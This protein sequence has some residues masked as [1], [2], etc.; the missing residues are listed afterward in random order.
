ME[1]KDLADRFINALAEIEQTKNLQPMVDLFASD[2]VLFNPIQI[3]GLRGLKNIR[4]FWQDYID[5]FAD[6]NTRFK[7]RASSG[8]FVVLE[9]LTQAHLAGSRLP[10]EYAGVTILEHDGQ[11][12]RQFNTYYD[13]A[14]LTTAAATAAAQNLR[15][16]QQYRPLI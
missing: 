1:Q 15:P 4:R 2:A 5:T 8:N 9:W 16:G 12:I 7:R 3:D 14:R 11:K 13:T 10:V 6:V